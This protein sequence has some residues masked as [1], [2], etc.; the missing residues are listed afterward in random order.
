[1]PHPV[2]TGTDTDS[3]ADP[4]RPVV[5]YIAGSGRSGSTL[6]ERTLGAMPG[7][8]NVGELLDLFRRVAGADER[9]GCGE[10]FSSC[11]FWTAVGERA[12]GGW[13]PALIDEVN[14]LQA[15]VARQRRIPNVLALQLLSAPSGQMRR[16]QQIY[17]DLYRAISQVSGARVIVDAS[18]WP[19]QAL[20]LAQPAVDLRLVAMVRDVRGVAHSQG[21]E[22]VARPQAGASGAAAMDSRGAAEAAARWTATQAE[23]ALL[24]SLGVPFTTVLYDDLVSQPRDTVRRLLHTLDLPVGPHHLDHIHDDSIDLPSSHGLSG[25]PSRFAHGTVPLRHDHAWKTAMPRTAKL[26]TLAIAAPALGLTALARRRAQHLP[27]ALAGTD[28]APRP[29]D[30]ARAWP[31]VSVVVTTRGR[32]E[33]V[34]ETLTGI[35]DQDYP[36]ELD[37]IVV[38]DQEEPDQRLVEEFTRPGRHLR[39]LLNTDHNP[40][41]AGARNTGLDVA[42]HDFVATSDDDDVW[43]PGKLRAQIRLLLDEPDLLAVGSGIRLL[44]PGRVVEWPGRSPRISHETLLRNRVK[45]LH[46]ST[47]VMRKDTFA[48]AGNY[49]ENLPHGYAEDYEFLLR[50]GQ[51]GPIGVVREPLADINKTNQSW[52]LQRSENTSEALKFLLTMHPELGSTRSGHARILGQIAFAESSMGHREEALSLAGKALARYPLAPHAYLALIQATTGVDPR[53]ALGFARRFGRGLS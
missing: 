45:E 24:G 15:R 4:G 18:K 48:K 31:G 46:S 53:K 20:A 52:F 35:V 40:G 6:L 43:H 7:Y 12:F 13:T 2:P 36:G 27:G 21:K 32:P 28:S 38:H 14:Q 23:V 41:L 47:L 9:C 8:V 1:M 3:H 37:I 30:A 29:E 50:V 11:A 39:V 33:L 34:R 5:V 25:N 10:L 19:S 22:S 42:E 16:Y 44:F 51:A 17:R 26:A 49:A